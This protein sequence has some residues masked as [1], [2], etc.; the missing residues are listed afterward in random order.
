MQGISDRSPVIQELLEEKI[1]S[2]GRKKLLNRLFDSLSRTQKR[3]IQLR[4]YKQIEYAE[5]CEILDLSYQ[6]ART[7]TCGGLLAGCGVGSLSE[8]TFCR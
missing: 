3:M 8:K 2:F 6:S 4:F 7:L 1:L 5:T